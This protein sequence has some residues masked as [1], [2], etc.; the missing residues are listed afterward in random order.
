MSV[1]LAGQC[2]GGLATTHNARST[3]IGLF[4]ANIWYEG[5]RKPLSVAL[6]GR[7]GVLF[8][9]EEDSLFPIHIFGAQLFAL[10]K[11]QIWPRTVGPRPSCPGPNCTGPDWLGPNLHRTIVNG[12]AACQVCCSKV[13]RKQC[14]PARRWCKLSVLAP[15]PQE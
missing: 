1:A 2:N 14:K 15:R 11:W 5:Q 8:L 13:D 4:F 6:T 10:K 3:C 12:A 9:V 7:R